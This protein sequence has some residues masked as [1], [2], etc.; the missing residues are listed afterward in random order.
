MKFSTPLINELQFE[1]A[2]TRKMLGR[3]PFDKPEWAPHSKSALLLG[4][5]RHV[6]RLPEWIPYIIE[7]DE[8][9]VSKSPFPPYPDMEKVE[10]LIA[11]FDQNVKQAED[12]LETAPDEDFMKPFTMRMGDHIIFT[13]PK[14]AVLRNMAFNHLVHHRGQMSVYLRLLDVPVPGMYGPSAD[15]KRPA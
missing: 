7:H 8:I 3:V 6:A 14:A 11:Y 4:L 13:L 15:E 5:A 2:N 1:A 12:A 9:D 10:D